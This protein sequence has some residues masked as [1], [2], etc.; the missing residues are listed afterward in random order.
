MRDELGRFCGGNPPKHKDKC[1]CFRCNKQSR[2]GKVSVNWKGGTSNIRGYKLVLTN[3][4]Y[5]LEHHLVWMNENQIHRIPDGCIIHHLNGDKLD[6]RIENL[7]LMTNGFHT[8]V[9][10]IINNRRYWGK[11]QHLNRR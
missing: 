7:Q 1:N 4:G 3:R 8:T 9:H 6:N 2:K 11:N 5:M 10:N